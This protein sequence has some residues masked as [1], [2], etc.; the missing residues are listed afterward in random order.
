METYYV[1]FKRDLT[2]LSR[3]LMFVQQM[4]GHFSRE[5]PVNSRQFMY[6]IC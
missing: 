1:D 6:S 4:F 2:L 3:K 5:I